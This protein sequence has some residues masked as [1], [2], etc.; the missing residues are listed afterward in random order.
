MK[1]VLTLIVLTLVAGCA[2]SELTVHV[3]L[4]DEDP[5]FVAPM[6]P[7]EMAEQMANLERLRAAA[8]DKTAQRKFLAELSVQMYNDTREP[9]FNKP[10]RYTEELATFKKAADGA[11]TE[12]EKAIDAAISALE[13]YGKNYQA[14]YEVA[15]RDF[16]RCENE[17]LG[18]QSKA[19]VDSASANPSAGES[20]PPAERPLASQCWLSEK[21]KFVERLDDE[22]I[23][24]R[25]PVTLRAEEATVRGNVAKAAAGYRS[26]AAPVKDSFVVDWAGL[27]ADLYDA[28]ENSTTDSGRESGARRAIHGLNTRLAS[29]A[30]T[31]NLV[32]KSDIEEA[33]ESDARGNTTGLFRSTMKIAIEL[34]SLRGDLPEDASAQTALSG[35]VRSSARFAELIDRLQDSG[36]PVWRTVTNPAN[37]AHWNTQVT[38][39]GFF[40]QGKSNVVIVRQDPMRY[41]IHEGTNDPAALIKAQLEVSRAVANAA[42]NVAG[43][44]AGIKVPATGTKADAAGGDA[45]AATS[46]AAKAEAFA[47]RK[48]TAE[49]QERARQN[50]MRGLSMELNNILLN[51]ATG[52][53]GVLSAQ[54]ARLLSVLKA[55]RNLFEIAA[56]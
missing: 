10:D 41:D 17:R 50:A 8:K 2:T 6:T 1:R 33:V 27:R 11:Q 36:D 12:I 3:D 4:Y 18:S 31:A 54:R 44:A 38:R 35:L 14:A 42:I 51:L 39:S 28:L 55:Y 37:E 5:R 56:D 30:Q 9:L 48:A 19:P 16:Q 25:L 21:G 26:F 47:Q 32:P 20:V 22:W 43:A 15:R 13:G 49:E 34:E 53:D 29:L 46:D 40:A 7:E 45:A 23:V 24:R 52:G